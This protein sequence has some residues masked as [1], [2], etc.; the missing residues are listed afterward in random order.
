MDD[1]VFKWNVDGGWEISFQKMVL[2]TY[3]VIYQRKRRTGDFGSIG[4][5]AHSSSS[6]LL[7]SLS[8][9]WSFLFNTL[10]P[11]LSLFLMRIHIHNNAVKLLSCQSE[12][13]PPLIL[14][15]LYGRTRWRAHSTCLSAELVKC[16]S[17]TC[18]HSI[19]PSISTDLANWIRLS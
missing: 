6:F 7:F 5:Y 12:F 14:P 2:P 17:C 10:G 19:Y 3:T 8:F 18:M 9:L 1:G 16:L 4:V 13:S 11:Y 15:S